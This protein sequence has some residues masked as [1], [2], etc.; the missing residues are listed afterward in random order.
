[1][2]QNLQELRGGHGESPPHL[3]LAPPPP[4]RIPPLLPG[5]LDVSSDTDYLSFY[6]FNQFIHQQ[7]PVPTS[8]RMPSPH[9]LLSL[10][11]PPPNYS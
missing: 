3:H 8:S 2:D 6:L 11:S 1:M 7:A 9:N 10:L 5:Q 4:H